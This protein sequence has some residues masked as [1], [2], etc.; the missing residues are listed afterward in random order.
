MASLSGIP[1][2]VSALDAFAVPEILLDAKANGGEVK[3]RVVQSGAS[4]LLSRVIS[5]LCGVQSTMPSSRRQPNQRGTW[6]SPGTDLSGQGLGARGS[7][8]PEGGVEG[9]DTPADAR[10]GRAL[11]NRSQ[12]TDE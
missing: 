12:E 8:A 7:P 5:G 10:K 4:S 1:G 6:E 9:G 2:K 11:S 3:L